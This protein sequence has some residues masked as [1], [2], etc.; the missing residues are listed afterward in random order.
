MEWWSTSPNWGVAGIQMRG[1]KA[2]ATA[3]NEL[4]AALD[5]KAVRVLVSVTALTAVTLFPRP[6]PLPD[7]VGQRR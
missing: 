4:L 1:A 6:S 2:V 5:D 7:R 3:R